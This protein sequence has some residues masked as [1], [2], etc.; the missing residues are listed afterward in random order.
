MGRPRQFD[1]ESI[2]DKATEVFW[3][4]GYFA[5]ST[6]DLEAATGLKRG[7]LY[8]AFKDKRTLFLAVI[9]HYADVEMDK[10]VSA[11]KTRSTAEKAVKALYRRI[12]SQAGPVDNRR[13]CLLC[14]AAVDL[15]PCDPE[16]GARIRSAL[17]PMNHALEKKITAEW[18]DMPEEEI[19]RRAG[20]AAAT[21]LGLRVMAKAGHPL[22]TLKGIA[23]QAAINI[24]GSGESE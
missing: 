2:L 12:I 14:D 6:E 7:S 5:T 3:R 9:D 23:D 11:I 18:P 13:G 16:I 21:Y 22:T 17:E 4:N 20:H 15:G 10:A 19:S 8:N 24:T 1:K